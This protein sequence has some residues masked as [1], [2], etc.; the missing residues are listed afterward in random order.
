MYMS[1]S[2]Q[3]GS[4]VIRDFSDIEKRLFVYFFFFFFFFIFW[5]DGFL[6]V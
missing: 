2:Y 4:R 1:T 3:P 6:I 5:L